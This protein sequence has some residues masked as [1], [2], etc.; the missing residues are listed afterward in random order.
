MVS[1]C[2]F[3]AMH[4]LPSHRLPIFGMWGFGNI[5]PVLGIDLTQDCGSMGVQVLE[6]HSGLT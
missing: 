5:R 3:D 6:R 2:A 1:G 4:A